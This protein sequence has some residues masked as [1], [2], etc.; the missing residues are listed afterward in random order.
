MCV[1]LPLPAS[2]S[3]ALGL[4]SSMISVAV[5]VAVAIVATIPAPVM[6]VMIVMMARRIAIPNWS[7]NDKVDVEERTRRPPRVVALFAIGPARIALVV[8][9]VVTEIASADFPCIAIVVIRILPGDDGHVTV[10]AQAVTAIFPI[11]RGAKMNV[12]ARA[13]V[14]TN[15]GNLTANRLDAALNADAF[16]IS[17]SGAGQTG[18]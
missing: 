16:Q 3:P 7:G 6:V 13:A 1:D 2:P 18:C 11:P 12:K 17:V 15:V 10:A 5:P 4:I 9:E 8:A 14:V